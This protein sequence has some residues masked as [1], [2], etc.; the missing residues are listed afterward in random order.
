MKD[1]AIIVFIYMCILNL[2]GYGMMSNDKRR[3]TRNKRR[4][5]ERNLFMVAWLGGAL[6][7]LTGMYQKRHKTQHTTFT[8]G[9]PFILLVNLFVYGFVIVKLG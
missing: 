5:P 1:M 2:V 9:I 8:A 3:A 7:V 4:I 6:G